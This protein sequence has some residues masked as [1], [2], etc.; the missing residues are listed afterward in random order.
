MPLARL[1]SIVIK[2]RGCMLATAWVLLYCKG[3]PGSALVGKWD[4]CPSL[5]NSKYGSAIAFQIPYLV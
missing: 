5:F 1:R 2:F 3:H 4:S